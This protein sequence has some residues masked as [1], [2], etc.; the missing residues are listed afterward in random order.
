M[1][2]RILILVVV[3]IAALAVAAVYGGWFRK[4]SGLQGS[5]T[6]EAR[7]HSRGFESGRPHP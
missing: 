6:V 3:V 1:T 2:R 4:D 7:K 5:G